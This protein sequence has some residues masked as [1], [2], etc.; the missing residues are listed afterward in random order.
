MENPNYLQGQPPPNDIPRPSP[1]DA[2][3]ANWGVRMADQIGNWAASNVGQTT[4]GYVISQALG[5][6]LGLIIKFGSWVASNLVRIFMIGREASDNSFDEITRV[7]IKDLLNVDVSI[8][9]AG[10]PGTGQQRHDAHK[11]IGAGILRAL[12]VDGAPTDHGTLVPSD[13]GAQRYLTLATKLALEGWLEGWL[14]EALSAGQMETFAELKDVFANV[15]GLNGIGPRV[16]GP[17]LDILCVTPYEWQLNKQYRPK[18]LSARQLARLIKQKKIQPDIA[19]EMLARQGYTDDAINALM[20]E[21]DKHFPANDLDYMYARGLISNDDAAA[22]LVAEGWHEDQARTI[23]ALEQDR[24][25]DT[26]Q[27]RLAEMATVAYGNNAIERDKLDAVL[28]SSG[29]PDRE[30]AFYVLQAQLARELTHKELSE[31][32][33]EKAYKLGFRGVNDYRAFLKRLGYSDVDAQTKELLLIAEVDN[34]TKAKAAKDAADKQRAADKAARDAELAK[35][36]QEAADRA[37]HHGLSLGQFEGLVRD[38]S[39]TLAQYE[40]F[41]AAQG[42]SA[43]D[44]ADLADE[45]ANQLAARKA[46]EDR[47]AELARQAKVKGISVAD[48]E[49][50]TRLGLLSIDDYGAFLSQHGY[51][52]EDRATLVRLLQEEIDDAT[53][54]EQAKADAKAKLA[55]KRISLDSLTRAVRAG[56]QTVDDYRARL[57]AEGFTDDS[58]DVMVSLLQS[59]LAAD[60]AARARRDQVAAAAAKKKL[61]LSDLERAVR[62]GVRPI[63]DYRAAVA[64]LGFATADQDTLVNLLQLDIDADKDAAKR[65]QVAADALLVKH[66]T[67]SEVERAV[68]LGVMTTD[69]YRAF[70]IKQGFVA[71]DV[72]VLVSS[73]VAEVAAVAKV[74]AA[75]D[76]AAKRAPSPDLSEATMR[77]AVLAGVRSPIEYQVLMQSQGYDASEVA[78]FVGLLNDELAQHKSALARQGAVD[79]ALLKKGISLSDFRAAVKAGVKSLDDYTAFLTEQGYGIEDTSTLGDLLSIQIAP[80]K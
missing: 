69:Q 65:R 62:S 53:E 9:G 63:G 31:G 3:A 71:D 80:K 38:G 39:R 23:L 37:A 4:F 15:L 59:D 22:Q 50:S 45:L 51:T 67:L 49:K 20:A 26:F 30:R 55:E 40:S 12:F 28:Q 78:T 19:R 66:I 14:M 54:A 75:R 56:L 6:T 33:M 79:T 77:R 42:Y 35:K 76:A 5:L 41:I 25:Y 47:R 70:L 44:A 46:A 73:L 64:G 57:T 36:R 48:V 17:A 58:A 7:A 11:E 52:D 72:S 61:S 34:A 43:Q 24:R 1:L 18:L 29:I 10:K 60:D 27:R 32:D 13:A 74:K 16:M 2:D 21:D 68:K 8:T